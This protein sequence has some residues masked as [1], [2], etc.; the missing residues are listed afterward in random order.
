MNKVC[1]VMLLGVC[2]VT[3]IG[4]PSA[5]AFS[6]DVRQALQMAAEDAR[7]QLAASGLPRDQTIS[8]L[9][10]AGDRNAYVEGLLKNAI[11]AAG[12]TY[13]EGR[14]DPFW[15]EVMKEVEWDERKEDML[16]PTTITRFGKLKSTQL[17]MYG[18]IRSAGQDGQRVFVEIELH[19]SAIE[20]KQH[21]W[22]T[23]LTR[24]FY[25][26][27]TVQGVVALDPDIRNVLNAAL[28]KGSE[29]LQGAQKLAAIRTVAVVPLAGD[30]DMYITQRATDILS[31]THMSPKNLDISTLGEARQILR[32]RPEQAD[33]VLYGALRDLSMRLV[34][35]EIMRTT[36]EI[37]AEVQLTIQAANGEV[38]WSDTVDHVAE[39]VRVQTGEEKLLEVSRA[40]PRLWFYIGGGIVG[41]ILLLM[42]LKASTRVR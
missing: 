42:F 25:L 41:F 10:L 6:D 35:E 16:D 22:G 40:N 29:S 19:V 4:A 31:R 14:Q 37:S 34:R 32:D 12:L 36:F 21:L 38:L 39:I 20:T 17:L 15:E 28:A 9:P 33:A 30:V 26:P 8:I 2:A 1:S 24:R 23:M 5:Q 3:M 11:T 18:T 27:G 7:S 13:V